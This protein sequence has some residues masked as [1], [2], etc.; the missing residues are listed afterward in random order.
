MFIHDCCCYI[1]IRVDGNGIYGRRD[2]DGGCS[3]RVSVSG[4]GC[5]VIDGFGYGGVI[6]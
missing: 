3:L 6:E 5:F 2:C 4:E 1:K